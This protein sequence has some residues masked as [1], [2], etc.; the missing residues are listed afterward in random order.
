MRIGIWDQSMG[1]WAAGKTY[2]TA[3]ARS[4]QASLHEDDSIVI[5]CDAGNESGAGLGYGDDMETITMPPTTPPSF[6]KRAFR[7]GT[8][9]AGIKRMLPHHRAIEDFWCSHGVDIVLCFC[10]PD[11]WRFRRVTVV[12]WIPDLQEKHFPEF[13]SGVELR[14]REDLN[15][16]KL[17]CCDAVTVSSE[18]VGEDVKKWYGEFLP[19]LVRFRFPSLYALAEGT[20]RDPSFDVA[21]VY[22]ISRPYFLVLNQ[23]WRHKNHM[24]VLEAMD[25]LRQRGEKIPTVV[26]IGQPTDYRDPTG[27]HFSRLL[28][29]GIKRKIA[30]HLRI[31]GFVGSAEKDSLLRNCSAVIQPSFSEGWNTSVEDAKALGKAVYAS[32]IPAHREQLTDNVVFFSPADGRMLADIM[33]NAP[34]SSTWDGKKEQR[35]MAD[36][37]CKMRGEAERYLA[38]LRSLV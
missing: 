18:A 20:L 5:L 25:D 21:R 26:M 11:P 35:S 2:T 36:A 17:Q 27:E 32:D 38:S 30:S 22:G 29:G 31:L 3:L 28:Q 4:V 1:R 8:D 24:V 13:F 23:F 19:K 37:R 16:M 6:L 33:L 12:S 9:F 15:I 7:K 34:F 10:L 14:N